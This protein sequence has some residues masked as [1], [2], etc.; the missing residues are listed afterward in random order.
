MW[1]SIS[2]QGWVFNRPKRINKITTSTIS[3]GCI[4][5]II[6]IF[7]PMPPTFH[8]LSGLSFLGRSFESG[9][10][11]KL[12]FS[13]IAAWGS[14]RHTAARYGDSIPTRLCLKTTIFFS[15]WFERPSKKV[16]TWIAVKVGG[17]GSKIQI[18]WKTLSTTPRPLPFRC[19][20]LFN[21]LSIRNLNI[22][23]FAFCFLIL[24]PA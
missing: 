12:S 14:S 20:A 19:G 2:K 17:I 15:P 24:I 16:Q 8:G 13:D 21:A 1:D 3:R 10:E 23:I 4:F 9:W 22:L 11:K 7:E 5:T 6:W 18:I